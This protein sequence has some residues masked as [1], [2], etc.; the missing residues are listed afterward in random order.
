[1]TSLGFNPWLTIPA[2]VIGTYGLWQE[3]KMNEKLLEIDATKR[4]ANGWFENRFAQNFPLVSAIS[5]GARTGF[6]SLVGAFGL[7]NTHLALSVIT[8]E[9]IK[10]S[11]IALGA[12]N[13]LFLAIGAGLT[14]YSGIVA[15][16]KAK[17]KAEMYEA[18]GT[19]DASKLPDVRSLSG[20]GGPGA[21]NAW[22]SERLNSLRGNI[23]DLLAT[24]ATA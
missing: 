16:N 20:T 7:S 21:A 22:F 18:Y 4:A 14:I 24:P 3:A 19:S 8:A 17:A 15:Y 9:G 12:L 10:A 23:T 13:P 5:T 6:W 2:A 1:M 11:A